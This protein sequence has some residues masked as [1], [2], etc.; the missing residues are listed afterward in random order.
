M[1]DFPIP[2]DPPVMTTAEMLESA[3][4]GDGIGFYLLNLSVTAFRRSHGEQR[5]IKAL[6]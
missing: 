2:E 6:L 1:N 4:C 5:K 3:E